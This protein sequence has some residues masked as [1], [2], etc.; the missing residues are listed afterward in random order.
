[1]Q[2]TRKDEAF[3]LTLKLRKSVS[4][5]I[6]LAVHHQSD[7]AVKV[8]A[9]RLEEREEPSHFNAKLCEIRRRLNEIELKRLRIEDRQGKIDSLALHTLNAVDFFE[10]RI[11]ALDC[12]AQFARAGAFV[13]V[14]DRVKIDK[15]PPEDNDGKES[16]STDRASSL[17][18][19]GSFRSKSEN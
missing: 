13:K 5:I 9:E 14:T 7:M 10:A 11:E 17:S 6:T 3:S 18:F 15:E 2:S 12:I 16:F 4:S 19:D 1:M 8:R